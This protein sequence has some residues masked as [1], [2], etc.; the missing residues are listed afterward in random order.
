M[1]NTAGTNAFPAA[2]NDGISLLV[3]K[4][5]ASATV[6][7]AVTALSTTITLT[8]GQ[9]ANLSP[10]GAISFADNGEVVYYG[11][12]AADV[13]SDL[14]RDNPSNHNAGAT[15]YDYVVARHHN[16]HNDVF[17]AHEAFMRALDT[18]KADVAHVHSA[19]DITSGTLDAARLPTGIS[20]AL[21][22][23]GS[24]S[25]AE[26]QRLDGVTSGIQS[27]LDLKASIAYVDSVVAGLLDDRGNYDASSNLFPAA[28]GSGTAGAVLKGDLW[29]ISVGG[30]LG[31]VAVTVGDV[32][33]AL[34]DTP[35]Q[36]ASNWALTENNF[37]YVAE[38]S[39]NKATDFSTLNNTLYPTT[40]AVSNLLAAGYQPLDADLTAIAALADPNADRI[41]FWDDSAGAY[42]YLTPGTN[43]SITGTT[44]D[45]AGGGGADSGF[46][47]V[48]QYTFSDG[49][50]SDAGIFYT[51]TSATDPTDSG[52]KFN[53]ADPFLTTSIY[54]GKLLLDEPPDLAGL[55]VGDFITVEDAVDPGTNFAQFNY[56]GG[57]IDNGTWWEVPV[58]YVGHSGT[59]TD[60]MAV[61]I[62]IKF[63]GEREPD[64]NGISADASPDNATT[65]WI[66][67]LDNLTSWPSAAVLTTGDR[68]ELNEDGN[69]NNFARY[70]LTGPVVDATTYWTIPVEFIS[71][72]DDVDFD[73]QMA[74]TLTVIGVGD[75]ASVVFPADAIPTPRYIKVAAQSEPNTAGNDLIFASGAGV[76]SSEAN[77]NLIFAVGDQ[78]RIKM[79]DGGITQHAPDAAL[80]D[81]DLLNSQIHFFLDEGGD[82]LM[83]KVKYSDGTVKSGEVALV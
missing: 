70:R 55:Q 76:N 9:G 7:N 46:V 77:G 65:L 26:F 41:L 81:A 63:T 32:V 61:T 72:S 59:L 43:L 67:K 74:L 71:D 4:D 56:A 28:G 68:I 19:A 47:E 64:N 5:N 52:I 37:G 60:A 36:T 31:G 49:T 39:A 48:Y 30:T 1:P 58:T 24:V 3:A 38:N 15:V 21:L 78:E 53:D 57:L 25:N 45:A 23:D 18:D 35:G 13:L 12:N 83:V 8:A 2:D 82:K 69:I 50:E 27:Q 54:F 73:D 79:R 34:V 10:S 6:L 20:A 14:V 33:R 42:A 51:D 44:L 29:T 11:S 16:V 80:D 66:A 75:F 62:R 22:A 40:Q 17:I